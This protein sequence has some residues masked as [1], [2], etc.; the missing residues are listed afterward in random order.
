[1]VDRFHD[2]SYANSSM[3][4]AHLQKPASIIAQNWKTHGEIFTGVQIESMQH[5]LLTSLDEDMIT[6]AQFLFLGNFL[7]RFYRTRL[8]Y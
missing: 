6:P 1:M 5:A 7:D 3:N 2:L 4:R 8:V